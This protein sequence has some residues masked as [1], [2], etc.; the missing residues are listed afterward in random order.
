MH[1]M[2]SIRSRP[3]NGGHRAADAQRTWHDERRRKAATGARELAPEATSSGGRGS[4]S[5][6]TADENMTCD[7]SVTTAPSSRSNDMQDTA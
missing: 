3:G 6:D 1:R 2:S 4:A 7:Q 5:V